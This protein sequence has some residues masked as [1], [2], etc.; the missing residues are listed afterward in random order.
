LPR[1]I[2]GIDDERIGG[3]LDRD[4]RWPKKNDEGDNNNF[5]LFNS[6]LMENLFG[7]NNSFVFTFV[8]SPSS[9]ITFAF[10]SL[11]TFEASPFSFNNLVPLVG[12]VGGT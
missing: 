12:G 10:G 6:D 4:K 1:F 9:L 8:V 7:N 11:I 2:S 5:V 3:D